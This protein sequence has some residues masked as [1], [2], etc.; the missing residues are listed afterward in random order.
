MCSVLEEKENKYILFYSI[1][2]YS[3]LFILFYSILFYSKYIYSVLRRDQE[4][5]S[6]LS[7]PS[8]YDHL[9]DTIPGR[10]VPDYV[11]RR[12]LVPRGHYVL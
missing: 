4:Y 5:C 8:P 3:I 1:L 6:T 7:E 11:G 2:F 12:Q 9:T 10:I